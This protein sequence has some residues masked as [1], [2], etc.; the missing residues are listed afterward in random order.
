MGSKNLVAGTCQ[1]WGIAIRATIVGATEYDRPYFPFGENRKP[2]SRER[3]GALAECR[4]LIPGV[5]GERGLH[6]GRFAMA[7]P[8]SIPI[9]GPY[10]SVCE[11]FVFTRVSSA[12][13]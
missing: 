2:A 8:Q 13:H 10:F 1:A 7:A 3:M 5:S 12:E 9:A 11:S 6:P 4:V